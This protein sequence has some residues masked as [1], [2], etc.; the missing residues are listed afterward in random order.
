MML[1]KILV[2]LSEEVGSS[3]DENMGEAIASSA[4]SGTELPAAEDSAQEESE[5]NLAL[6]TT[7]IKNE[8]YQGGI[9]SKWEAS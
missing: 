5:N 2:L 4:I 1:M 6:Q 8:N 7:N 9:S 3:N